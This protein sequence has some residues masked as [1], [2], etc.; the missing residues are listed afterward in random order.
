MRLDIARTQ[1]VACALL[2]AAKGALLAVS[3]QRFEGRSRQRRREDDVAAAHV[4]VALE[5]G[6]RAA[7]RP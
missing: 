7:W 2:E 3:T 4:S 1:R 5:K 6:L